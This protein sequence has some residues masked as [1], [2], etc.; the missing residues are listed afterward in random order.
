MTDLLWSDPTPTYGFENSGDEYFFFNEARKIAFFYTYQAVCTFLEDNDLL[1]VIRAHEAKDA[2]YQ[3]YRRSTFSKFPSLI[4]VF[5]APNYCD[6]Y[7]NK[8][9]L[10]CYDGSTLNVKVNSLYN[11]LLCLLATCFISSIHICFFFNLCN[12]IA[13]TSH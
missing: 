8:G 9:V 5:S 6:T 13:V 3:M 11:S 12:S 2:G 4:T 1:S 10:L 7:K